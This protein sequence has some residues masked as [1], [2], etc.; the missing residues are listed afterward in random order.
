MIIV[1]IVSSYYSNVPVS[2]ATSRRRWC[3]WGSF[4]STSFGVAVLQSPKAMECRVRI[5]STLRAS[6]HIDHPRV[7]SHL[8]EVEAASENTWSDTPTGWQKENE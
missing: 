8:F 4:G 1:I 5:G 3:W 6:V 7:T 2:R